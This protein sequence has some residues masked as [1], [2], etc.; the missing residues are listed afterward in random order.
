M[1]N[2]FK[3]NG[4]LK[5]PVNAYRTHGSEFLVYVT[6]FTKLVKWDDVYGN[7]I[8]ILTVSPT[9]HFEDALKELMTAQGLDKEYTLVKV[10]V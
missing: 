3:A 2:R 5:T 7:R 9:R 1:L 4:K 8:A 10:A 6:D